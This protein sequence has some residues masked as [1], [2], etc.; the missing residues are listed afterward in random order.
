VL[1]IASEDMGVKTFSS[2]KSVS[3]EA[4][5]GLIFLEKQQESSPSACTPSHFCNDSN[6][7]RTKNDKLSLHL[8][9]VAKIASCFLVGIRV[10]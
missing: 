10:C 1:N 6:L 4:R 2:F 8:D 7:P 5:I 3:D 9:Q